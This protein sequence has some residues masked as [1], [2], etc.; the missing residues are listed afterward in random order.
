MDMAALE[1][2]LDLLPSLYKGPGGVAAVIRE[3]E[4]IAKRAWGFADMATRLPMA[5]ATRLPI[6]SISKQFTCALL[7]DLFEDPSVLDAQV[8]DFLPEYRD[9]LPTIAELCHNQS[10][11]RDYWA[12]TVLQGAQPEGEFRRQDALPLLA[13]AKTGHFRAGSH[14]SYSNGNYRLLAELIERATGR[15]FA[16]LMNERLFTPAGMKTAVWASD[17]RFPVDGVVGYEGNDQVGFLPAANGIYWVGDAGISASLDDMIAWEIH[18]DATRQDPNGLYN[19]LCRPVTFRDGTPAHY[20]YGLRRDIIGGVAATGHGGAL[21]GFQSHR[22]H[23]AAE[24]LSVIVIFNHDTNAAPACKAVLKAALGQPEEERE[25]LDIKAWGGLWLDR[26]QR[27]LVRIKESPT[28]AVLTYGSS[29]TN[30][31]PGSDDGIAEGVGVTV[32]RVGETLVIDRESENL[33]VTAHRIEPV[34]WADGTPISGR[35]WSEELGAGLDIL[36]RDGATYVGFEG[37]LGAGPVER[38]YAVADDLWVVSTRRSMDAPAPGDWTVQMVRDET[39][40]VTG[41]S[42]GCWLARNIGYVRTD[43]RG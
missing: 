5:A 19:R 42:L 27:L 37:M 6:C 18:I 34:A 25:A 38:M 3:G 9:P 43:S 4:V 8:R 14:Y 39:G 29:S 23:A 11:L 40:S 13:R 20:G 10:G 21:R 35:Y 31:F 12:L 32:Q 41:L 28:G 16:E 33:R 7:L 1:R 30:L 26:E 36:A 22:L 2:T 24:R 17:T 15:D